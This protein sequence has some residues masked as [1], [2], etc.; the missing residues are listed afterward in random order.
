ML[1]PLKF[2]ET[3]LTK[4]CFFEQILSIFI[5]IFIFIAFYF[6]RRDIYDLHHAT[7]GTFF[8]SL[9]II[10]FFFMKFIMEFSFDI[11]YHIET[12]FVHVYLGI[13][14]ASLITGVITDCIK[15]AVGRPRPNFFYRCFPNK[16]PVCFRS[17]SWYS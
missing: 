5:P 16:I 3:N 8:C 11:L 12:N 6:A 2:K 10:F 1:H 9:G 17:Y 7:L 4:C 15:D 14:F 13:L